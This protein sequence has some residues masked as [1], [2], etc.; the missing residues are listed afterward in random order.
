MADNQ[1]TDFNYDEMNSWT[2]DLS[3][4]DYNQQ[5]EFVLPDPDVYTVELVK[6][7]P[8]TKVKPEFNKSDKDKYQAR[9]D[10]KIVDDP[11]FDQTIPMWM[12]I[13]LNEKSTLLPWVEAL[14]GFKLQ[15]TDHIG[16][17][18]GTWQDADGNEFR[19]VGLGGKRCRA[20]LSH[21]T[22]KAG[23]TYAKLT[24][25]IPIRKTRKAKDAVEGPPSGNDDV[26]F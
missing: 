21:Y 16:W 24:G 13:T 14:A 8:T 20:T 5:P 6:K 22:N 19:T 9:F 12:N 25:P 11:D 10:F 4:D 23:K 2:T 17:E 26:P 3:V 15:P 18:D 7:H 1:Q